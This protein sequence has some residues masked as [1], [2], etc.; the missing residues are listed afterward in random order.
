V[1]SSKLLKLNDDELSC[2]DVDLAFFLFT[3]VF[4]LGR[5]LR[6]IKIFCLSFS[7]FLLVYVC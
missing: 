1:E 7:F 4:F 2:F 3:Y 5:S 6:R